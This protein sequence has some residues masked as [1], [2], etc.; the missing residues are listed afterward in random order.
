M[1]SNLYRA[2]LRLATVTG[3]QQKPECW[4]IVDTSNNS[5]T[6]SRTEASP[7]SSSSI[8][9][10]SMMS[11]AGMDTTS[12]TV[13]IITVDTRS[14]N[15]RI[16]M[17]KMDGNNRMRAEVYELEDVFAEVNHIHILYHYSGMTNLNV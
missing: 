17:N 14:S 9:C 12:M 11:M 5:S 3:M 15:S 8:K 1:K 10:S 2:L 7:P 13:A 6:I 16:G 4:R